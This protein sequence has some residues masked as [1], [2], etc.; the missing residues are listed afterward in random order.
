M[1]ARLSS[2]PRSVCGWNQLSLTAIA[3]LHQDH[4]A[5]RDIP[6][7][8]H[9]R[10]ERSLTSRFSRPARWHCSTT[11][12]LTVCPNC[13]RSLPTALP[14]CTSCWTINPLPVNVSYHRLFGF[15]EQNPFV[16]DTKALK[17]KF[18]EA[19][20]VCHPDAWASKGSD[21]QDIAQ[22]LSS[23]VNMAYRTLLD[24]IR[25]AEYIL[26]I[27]GNQ[28]DE[29]DKLE[30][31]QLIGD[32]IMAME[33]ISEAEDKAEVESV[34]EEN[35]ER[36]DTVYEA[37]GQAIARQDWTAAKETTIRAKSLQGISDAAHKWLDQ[38]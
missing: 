15:H 32:V 17:N 13:K 21:K 4:R 36:L 7:Y 38:Q 9:K 14:A 10:H 30:D 18:R 35:D 23:L 28:I 12:F 1:L 8:L 37:L 22:N 19:Q 27:N 24:P 25:R 31:T 11:A 29:T 5:P 16:V 3:Q 34:L 26:E 6:R 33:T 20:A 2:G